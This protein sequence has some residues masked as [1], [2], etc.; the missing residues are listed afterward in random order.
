MLIETLSTHLA[1]ERLLSSV[2]SYVGFK[3]NFLS[4]TLSTL[5]A[6][7]RLFSGVNSFMSVKG[8]FLSETLSTLLAGEGFSGVNHHVVF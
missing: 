6:G 4:E 5:L 1:G 8:S 3:A 2:N 7:V